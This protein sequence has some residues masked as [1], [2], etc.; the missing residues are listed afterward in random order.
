VVEKTDREMARQ[1]LTHAREVC[2]ESVRVWMRSAQIER[3]DKQFDRCLSLVEGALSVLKPPSVCWKLFLIAVHACMESGHLDK[4]EKWIER[5][6]DVCPGKGA[7]W[8]VAADVA[9]ANTNLNKA[10]SILER[11][12]IRLANDEILW[13]KGYVV[14]VLAGG[15]SS[16]GSRVFLS[17]ALQAC[18]PSG[19][20]WAYAIDHEPVVTRHPKCLDALKKCE[21]DPLVVIAVARFF[22]LEKKQIDKARKWFQNA[23]RMEKKYGQVWS[24]FL[25]FEISQGDENFFNFKIVLDEIKMLDLVETNKGIEWNVFRKRLDNWGKEIVPLIVEYSRERFP[26]IWENVSPRIASELAL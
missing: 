10:R 7:V 6:I 5:A 1:I 18:P 11:G 16:S 13:W 15:S 21:N 23:T 2:A 9:I 20:L 14:E 22:W 4:A 19:L 8:S 12:R 17:R 24:D 3:W 25:A 26:G